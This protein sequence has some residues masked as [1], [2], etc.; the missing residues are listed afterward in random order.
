MICFLI[1][2]RFF[3]SEHFQITITQPFKTKEWK[4][5][6]K[7]IFNFFGEFLDFCNLSILSSKMAEGDIILLQTIKK[8]FPE[9]E[10]NF[11][12]LGDFTTDFVL[13]VTAKLLNVIHSPDK[14]FKNVKPPSTYLLKV[15]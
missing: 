1:D 5:K 7:K 8:L 10:E 6:D 14:P 15:S 11:T 3:I 13:E 2:F 4:W 12:K 9:N